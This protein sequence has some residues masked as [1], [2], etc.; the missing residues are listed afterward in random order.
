MGKRRYCG[1]C[2]YFK[3]GCTHLHSYRMKVTKESVACKKY[4]A[5]NVNNFRSSKKK[6]DN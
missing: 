6:F 5:N 4:K 1:S 2:K 3:N